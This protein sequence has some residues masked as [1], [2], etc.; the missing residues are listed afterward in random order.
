[1][2]QQKPEKKVLEGIFYES[3]LSEGVLEVNTYIDDGGDLLK[4]LAERLNAKIKYSS[5]DDLP[6]T[7]RYELRQDGQSV[8][9][10]LANIH[11][12]GRTHIKFYNTNN[13]SLFEKVK[14]MIM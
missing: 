13:N 8:K 11:N 14:R 9:G 12:Q 2:E 10:D 6:F 3:K 1:M 4:I 7:Q 5:M